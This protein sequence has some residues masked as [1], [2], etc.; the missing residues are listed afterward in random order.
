[1]NNDSRL[2]L[3]VGHRLTHFYRFAILDF[4]VGPIRQLSI[5]FRKAGTI[6]GAIVSKHKILTR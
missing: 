2:F 1:M 3:F 5:D 6:V 4:Y